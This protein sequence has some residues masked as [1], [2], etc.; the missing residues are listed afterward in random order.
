M[1]K[2]LK[3][4]LPVVVIFTLGFIIWRTSVSGPAAKTQGEK[5]AQK[6]S[7]I[8]KIN[9]VNPQSFDISGFVGKSAL[10]AT[11][12]EAKVITNGTGTNAYIVSINGREADATKHEFWELDVNGSEAQVGAGSYIIQNNDEIQWKISNY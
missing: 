12:S 8:L 7:A 2:Y 5:A 11:E 1:K 9:D 10:E 6:V 3:L 4:I